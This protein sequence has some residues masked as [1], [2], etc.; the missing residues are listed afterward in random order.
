MPRVFEQAR[1]G[2][3]L[4]EILRLKPG[5]EKTRRRE[6]G[7]ILLTG[8]P[9]DRHLKRVEHRFFSARLYEIRI[10]YRIDRL[11]QGAVGLLAQL[12]DAYGPPR[13][14]REEDFDR[15]HGDLSRWGTVW[16]DAQTRL[17]LLERHYVHDAHV[18]I[19]LT[20]TMTDQEL[21]RRYDA[22]Q[23]EQARRKWCKV[24]IPTPE[25]RPVAKTEAPSDASR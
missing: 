2:M 19:A 23:E 17:V 11:P 13:L 20:L 25:R 6:A 5:L 1:L 21:A 4:G 7:T 3:E 24:P 22:A 15:E 8:S 12:K 18:L 9:A 14:D 16:E 10:S